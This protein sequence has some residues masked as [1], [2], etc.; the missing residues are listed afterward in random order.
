MFDQESYMGQVTLFSL[1]RSSYKAIERNKIFQNEGY[2]ILHEELKITGFSAVAVTKDNNLYIFFPGTFYLVDLVSDLCLICGVEN[3]QMRWD[4]PKFLNSLN[5]DELSPK[6]ISIYAH[7]LGIGN[8]IKALWVL[9]Q[10][11]YIG[12]VNAFALE[13]IGSKSIGKII[14]FDSIPQGWKWTSINSDFKN[15]FNSTLTPFQDPLYIKRDAKKASSN[16]KLLKKTLHN[17]RSSSNSL[18]N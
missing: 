11:K 7:S 14:G 13:D 8:Q 16:S 10:N 5:L 3:P 4:V 6:S 18:S 2:N 17:F 15:S 1:L 12:N 9:S